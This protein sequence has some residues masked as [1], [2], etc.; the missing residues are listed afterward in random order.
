MNKEYDQQY[1]KQL[2]SELWS[3]ILK[4]RSRLMF[5]D[6]VKQL[7]GL[8]HL[9]T[10]TLFC[11]LRYMIVNEFGS[12]VILSDGKIAL[13][14]WTLKLIQRSRWIER[15]RCRRFRNYAC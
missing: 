10:L 14:L 4:H 2:P 6:R 13:T 15:S 3:M 9:R 11:M 12:D 8:L 5:Y 1:M 7:E